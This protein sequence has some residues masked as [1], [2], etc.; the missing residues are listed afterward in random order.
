MKRAAK[1][2]VLGLLAISGLLL[3]ALARA[4]K[5]GINFIGG[6]TVNGMP[7]PLASDE[8]AGWIPQKFWNNASDASGS[9]NPEGDAD[10]GIAVFYSGFSASWADAYGIRSTP[11]SDAGGNSRL[12]KGYLNSD[13][14]PT[15]SIVVTITNVPGVFTS[16]GYAVVVYFDGDNG[17]AARVSKFTLSA[18]NFGQQTLYGLDKANTDFAGTFKEVPG[19]S[20][21]DLG[22][23]TPDGNVLVFATLTD[24]A[25]TLT[26]NGASTSDLNSRAALNA[27]QIVDARLLPNPPGPTITSSGTATGM[28]NAVFSYAITAINNPTSFGASGLPSGLS[29]N[30]ASGLISGIPT[31]AG[32][33]QVTLAATNANGSATKPLTLTINPAQ[34]NF[35]P[36]DSGTTNRLDGASLWNADSGLIAGVGGTLLVTTDGGQTWKSLNTGFTNDLTGI[37]VIDTTAFLIGSGGLIARSFDGGLSWTRFALPT[38][39]VF[40]DLSFI[41][42]NYGFVVGDGG[43]IAFY[44]GSDWTIQASGVTNDLFA[45]QSVGSTAYAA[46]AGGSILRYNGTNWV[47]LD[48]GT[49]NTTFYDV[50]FSD[51]NVGYVVGSNGTLCRTLNGGADW[52]PLTS[53]VNTSLRA[54]RIINAATVVV[55]GDN[56]VVLF[57]TD[58]GSNWSRLST[59]TNV[60]W[61]GLDFAGGRGLLFGE[62]GV[63]YLFRL[64]FIP[65]NQPPVV[66]IIE[67]TNN[68]AIVACV[69]FAVQANAGDPDGFVS[70]VEFYLNGS[71]LG[72]RTSGPYRIGWDTDAVG[73]YTLTTRATDNNGAIGV[74]AP[75]T[76][77]IVPPPLHNLIVHGFTSNGAFRLCFGGAPGKSYTVQ[78]SVNLADWSDLGTIVE[79]NGILEFLDVN[80][81]NFNHRFYRAVQQ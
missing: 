53:G 41:N 65:V 40:H 71:K 11:V 51:E 14:T 26:V 57:T 29:V 62:G 42:P 79:T 77:V 63:I 81:T 36:L 75:V 44:N 60:A 48:S 52:T 32:T 8:V 24:S 27:I 58:G 16:A 3:P 30:P 73:T 23:S 50:A 12:M 33:F 34:V 6:S 22:G 56:G 43:T 38:T 76:V 61:S 35:T 4:D 46:G 28:I 18:P 47:A 59:G 39:F 10:A 7:G 15:G 67:P 25:F 19:S 55:A 54:I 31:V 45:V 2:I 64:V 20:T 69:P 80:A 66:T 21:S 17:G 1:D 5:V 70:R 49:T 68:V 9:L 13:D 78:G 72:E 74:S 37:R